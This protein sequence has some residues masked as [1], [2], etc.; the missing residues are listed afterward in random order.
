MSFVS[1]C[2]LSPEL[3][4][5]ACSHLYKCLGFSCFALLHT[6]FR[7]CTM[8]SITS[9]V[10]FV[11]LVVV[12]AR[13][14]P[15]PQDQKSCPLQ[16]RVISGFTAASII[17]SVAAGCNAAAGLIN[18][19]LNR[20]IDQQ[21]VDLDEK[22]LKEQQRQHD[23]NYALNSAKTQNDAAMQKIKLQNDMDMADKQ[24]KLSAQKQG[25]FV[26]LFVEFLHRRH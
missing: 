24:Y 14:I 21:K 17:G 15:L 11:Q 26:L 20:K 6:A 13:P 7:F 9:V 1:F 19:S 5:N 4:K 10:L 23:D 3:Y 22:R 12:I 16:K 18:G 25:K 2:F 8:K